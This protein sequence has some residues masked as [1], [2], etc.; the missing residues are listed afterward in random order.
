MTRA[1]DA[2]ELAGRIRRG[3]VTARQAVEESIARIEKRNP[4]L[5]AV[6]NQRFEAA[7]D[8]VDAGLPDGPL[9]GVPVLVKDLH[10]DVAGMPSTRGSRLWA[11]AVAAHDSELVARYR[12]AGMVVLGT[13]NT[14]ELGKNA[15]TEPALFGPARNPWAPDRSPGGSSGGSAAAVA[16]GMVPVAHGNDGGGSIRIPASMCGLFGLKPTRG[17]V[18]PAPYATALSSPVSIHHA[19][20]TSVRDSALLLDVAS[21]PVRGDAYGAP[22]GG[23]F[24]DEVGRDPGRLR[25]G[26]VASLPV[27][28]PTHPDCVA[29]VERARAVCESLGH[30]TVEVSLEYDAPAMMAASGLIMGA[31]LVR[32]VDARL[33]ELGR[34]L[35]DDDLEP[36]TR[37]MLEHYRASSAAELCGA[38][39]VAETTGWQVGRV[40]GEVDVLLMPVLSQPAPALGTLD[41]SRPEVMYELGTVYSYYTSLFNVTGQPGMSVPF[42]TDAT[43]VPTGAQFVADIGQEA[44]LL[45]LAGQLERAA[46]WPTVAPG[47]EVEPDAG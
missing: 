5:N 30:R 13:T 28:L 3:E 19:L 8:E 47:Y 4:E 33:V 17:R 32:A 29:A 46:P 1:G 22:G 44:L 37:T 31:S 20:T 40:F 21:G 38:L 45:R 18:S 42:G 7:L 24:L 14:P 2:I 43:G 34:P 10:A 39:Q 6:V 16:S 11:D 26:V 25:I 36:F 23:P 9:R 27:G 15:S 41:T 12:R 35:A